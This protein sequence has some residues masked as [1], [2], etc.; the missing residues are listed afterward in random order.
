LVV[1][2]LLRSGLLTNMLTTYHRSRALVTAFLDSVLA[3]NTWK[4]YIRALE[5]FENYRS[6]TVSDIVRR[7]REISEVAM[8]R[9]ADPFMVEYK[10]LPKIIKDWSIRDYE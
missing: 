4:T 5:I 1:V 8:L 2:T 9:N 10:I 6:Q 7:R 3:K